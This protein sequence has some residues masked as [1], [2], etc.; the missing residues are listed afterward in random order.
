MN[1]CP[2]DL[3]RMSAALRRP[4]SPPASIVSSS[5]A[6]S[7]SL[8]QSKRAPHLGT[9]GR[10]PVYRRQPHEVHALL[11]DLGFEVREDVE[12]KAY[13]GLVHRLIVARYHPPA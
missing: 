8:R 2:A 4:R 13:L 7:S 6:L 12:F 10:E 1:A 3:T 9:F 11:T 5:R